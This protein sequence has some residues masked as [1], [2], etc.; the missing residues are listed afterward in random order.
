[1]STLGVNSRLL[2]SV[3]G[4][5]M[6]VQARNVPTI[7]VPWLATDLHPDISE[8]RETLENRRN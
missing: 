7:S 4:S 5:R 8:M 3:R 1:M 6:Q 2:N